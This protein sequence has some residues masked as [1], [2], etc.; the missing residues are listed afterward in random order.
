MRLSEAW[1]R[2]FV[3]PPVETAALVSQL[4]MAGIEVDSVEP[5]SAAFSGV[6]VAEVIEVA[7]HPHADRLKVCQVDDGS[8]ELLQIVCGAPN[9]AVGL[10]APLA[11][12]GALLPG[13]AQIRRSELRGVPS[14]GM[15]CSAKELGLEDSEGGLMRLPQDSPLGADLRT[16]LKLDDAVL[17]IDLTPNRADCLSVEGIAREAAMLNRIDRPLVPMMLPL[18]SC[19]DEFPILVS[20]PDACPRYLG[21]VIRNIHGGVRAPLWMRERLRRSGLRSLDP[22]VDVTN[23]VLLELGQPLHAFDLG[24]LTGGIE[25]RFARAGEHLTLLNDETITPDESTLVIADRQQVLALA[26]VMGGRA[27]AVSNETRDLFLE[28]AYFTPAVI[29]GRAR[30]YGLATDSS[31]RFERG[32]DPELQR[33]ALE[34]A[35]QMIL[36]LVGG[37]AGPVSDVTYTASLP[38]VA[39]ITL[40]RARIERL[41]GVHI[42][43]DQVVDMLRRLHMQVTRAPQGWRVTPPSFRFDIAQEVDLIE[44]LGR[45]LGYDAVPRRRPSMSTAMRAAS[46]RWLDPERLRDLLVD[47]GYQEVITYSFVDP[48]LQQKIEPAVPVLPLKNPISS[49]MAVM[50]TTLW[51]GLIDAA[52]KNQSRQQIRVRLFELGSTFVGSPAELVQSRC[53]AGLAMGPA[54]AEQWGS[55]VVPVDYFDVKAD[56]EAL[57]GLGGCREAV[58]FRSAEHAALHPGQSARVAIGEQPVGWLGMLHPRLENFLGFDQRVFLFH[59]DLD[60]LLQRVVGK[61]QPLSRFPRVRRD[62]A[63]VVDQNVTAQQVTDCVKAFGCD[64]LRE[65]VL[66]DVYQGKGVESGKKSIAVGLIVQDDAE[67]LTDARVDRLMSGIVEHLQNELKATLRA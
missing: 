18:I 62:I 54:L 15:L 55:A 19:R 36:D 16:V 29:M 23:Y 7:P 60:P 37:Q 43:D 40:R 10:R 33:R 28:C 47:R 8:G 53:L 1:L 52:L 5:A 41:L 66:F 14:F 63:L 4:T 65:V 31:H 38:S 11:I 25:V 57:L 26:G 22:V 58:S 56:L 59:L 9:A 64:L 12:E 46:E 61:F 24:K 21:R 45:V 49:D 27:S 39:P 50:R 32:V 2:E 6:V 35:T 30:R 67:T 48:G 3:D 44:E 20:A 51:G 34:R 17:Q 42:P 13:G